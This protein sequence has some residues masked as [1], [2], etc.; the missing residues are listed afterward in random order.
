MTERRTL[1]LRDYVHLVRRHRW[2]VI[3]VPI[4]VVASAVVFSLVQ[5]PVYASS[6]RLLVARGASIFAT[7]ESRADPDLVLTEIELLKSQPV[8]ALVRAKLG[9]APDVSAVQVGRTPLVEVTTENDS[10]RRAAATTQAYMEEY[11]AFKRQQS[12]DALVTTTREIQN[13]IDALQKEVDELSAELRNVNCPPTPNPC[14]PREVIEQDRDARLM[15]LVPFRQK[16]AQLYIDA[17]AA[18]VGAIV[19][20]AERPTKP[21]RPNP[22]RSGLLALT[23]GVA[24]GVGLAVVFGHLDDSIWDSEDVDASVPGLAVLAV[25]PTAAASENRRR[26]PRHEVVSRSEPSSPSAEAYRTLRTSIRLLGVDRPI[27]SVQVTSASASEGKTTT[28]ANLAWVLSRAGEQVIMVNCDFRR[29]RLHEYFGL[30]NEVGLTSLLLGEATLPEAL[31]QVSEDG[32]LWLL[33]AGP[34]PPNPSDLLSS[35]RASS[36]L[37]SVQSE[38]TVV[39]FDSPAVLPVTDAAVL[40]AK[41]DATILV[42]RGGVSTRKQVAR[43]VEVLRQV[44]APLVGAVLH[45]RSDTQPAYG[46]GDPSPGDEQDRARNWAASRTTTGSPE[47][48][49]EAARREHRDDATRPSS[50]NGRRRSLSPRK[51]Q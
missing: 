21:V 12:S 50:Q 15:E 17:S 46:Y 7:T 16:L 51:T 49:R 10:P 42:V 45:T 1:A 5:D 2:F 3:A 35:S 8:R 37:A 30:S 32:R 31:Q 48:Q 9:S 20:P 36:V 24:L 26:L 11:L 28:T 6:G 25:I 41:V 27:R 34:R 22:V 23:L 47:G 29:P 33:A 40:S 44:G 4:V 38:A 39:V 14:P 43:A 13:T 18:N 19:S